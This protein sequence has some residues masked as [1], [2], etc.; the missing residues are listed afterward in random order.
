MAAIALG[1]FAV[2]AY[3]AGRLLHA[4]GLLWATDVATLIAGAAAVA[5]PVVLVL[6][7]IFGGL[8][9][10][11]PLSPLTLEQARAGYAAALASQWAHED[12]LRQVNDP[13]A[14]PVRW[15]TSGPTERFAD[16]RATFDRAPG[17]RLV[18]LGAAGAGK[19]VLASKLVRELLNP[20]RPEDPV[21]VLLPAA[22]WT[23]DCTMTEWITEQIVRS[24][25]SLNVRITTGAGEKA[26]LPR[27][28]AESGLIPV[29]DGLD[30][31]PPD[32]WSTVITEI[33]AAGSDSPLVLTSRPEEYRSAT[34]ER[35]ISRAVVIELEPLTGQEIKD[36]LAQA[37]DKPPGRWE[38]VFER[39]QEPGSVLAQTLGAPLMTW[40]ARTVY[41]DRDSRPADLLD[42]ADRAAIEAHLVQEFVPAVYSP[43]QTKE[44]KG[45][46][47]CDAEQATRWLGFLAHRLDRDEQQDIA[48]WQLFLGGRG[49]LIVTCAIRT[50]LSACIAWQVAV[51]VLTRR[52]YWKDGAYTGHGH[53]LDL[54][55]AGPLGKVVRPLANLIAGAGGFAFSA[56]ANARNPSASLARQAGEASVHHLSER[57]DGWLRDVAHLG[58]F[59]VACIAAGLGVLAGLV[60]MLD[61]SAPVPTHLRP[62]GRKVLWRLVNPLPWLLVVGVV[63]GD[64]YARHQALAAVVRSEAGWLALAWLGLQLTSSIARSLKTPIEISAAADPVSLL[65]GTRR[66]YLADGAAGAAAV[67]LAWL[68]SG[69]VFAIADSIRLALGLGVVL[70]LGGVGG[71]WARYVDG[72]LRLAA[73]GWLPLRTL[74]FLEDAHRRGV[75]RQAGAVYQFRHIRLQQ[76]LAAGYSAWPRQLRPAAAWTGRQLARLRNCYPLL[77]PEPRGMTPQPGGTEYTAV[78]E[79]GAIWQVQAAVLLLQ[80]LALIALFVVEGL[81]VPYGFVVVIAMIFDVALVLPTVLAFDKVRAAALL[82]PWRRTIHVTPDAITLTH[83]TDQVRLTVGDVDR[84]ALRPI[85]ESFGCYAVQ[86]RL[87]A[88]GQWIPLYWTP[89]YTARIPRGLVSALAGFAGDRL[90]KRLTHWL[91]VLGTFDEAVYEASGTVEVTGVRAA[92]GPS[93]AWLLVALAI[94]GVAQVKH[95]QNLVALAGLVAVVLAGRF[96]YLLRMHRVRKRLPRGPWSIH[97]TPD[98]IE[99]I[100]AGHTIRLAPSDIDRIEMHSIHRKSSY[101]PL[102]ARLR[103]DV[104]KRLRVTDGWYIL[105]WTTGY[106]VTLPDDLIVALAIFAPSRLAGTLKRRARDAL[107]PEAPV[108]GRGSQG[109]RERAG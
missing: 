42:I 51:W 25:P 86:A 15:T 19:S 12:R 24:Q 65:R 37:T 52:G 78:L 33:N 63:V 44:R 59:P 34:A 54:L 107:N 75:L 103:P 6:G 61:K 96:L 29:I 50:V 38:S 72:R 89:R 106:Y 55:L 84:I 39:L 35:D 92:L 32:R 90:D 97:L 20:R 36:Y 77:T 95:Q 41:Q 9:G 109:S 43:R 14:M 73:L 68:W 47:H 49:L 76:Q 18:I 99:V 82:S 74:S 67:G 40:L 83:G 69:G 71:A 80:V 3:L 17:H 28:L 11:P 81:F 62:V 23:R 46:F 101:T 88:G 64:S 7:K 57:M 56:Q 60:S 48:W 70:L 13:E 16:I 1:L 8:S 98:A 22:S 30:E 100:R 85:G 66:T 2:C 45:S 79:G 5:S 4:K 87:R 94:T 104:A 108:A 93:L 102:C 105:Y 31:L 10:A 21:P 27:E 53:Y 91:N 26:W 58:L